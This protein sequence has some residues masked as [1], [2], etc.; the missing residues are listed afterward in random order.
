MYLLIGATI[1][2]LVLAAKRKAGPEFTHGL[3]WLVGVLLLQAAIGYIQHFTGLPIVLVI[4]H[5]LGSAL[6]GIATT[7][8]WDRAVRL[9]KYEVPQHNV[10]QL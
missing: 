5:M 4:L 2:L 9:P 10:S 6:L 8:V 7:N 1:V 3:Y